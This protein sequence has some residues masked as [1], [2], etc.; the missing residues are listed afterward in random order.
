[1]VNIRASSKVR[2]EAPTESYQGYLLDVS[3]TLGLLKSWA[4][5]RCG[6]VRYATDQNNS[7][8]KF[9]LARFLHNVKTSADLSS[10][11]AQDAEDLQAS[12][13]LADRYLQQFLT[14]FMVS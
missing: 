14:I 7:K 12:L 6:S 4:P 5:P 1:M 9:S 11:R 10:L 3:Q 2:F 8:T 13:A